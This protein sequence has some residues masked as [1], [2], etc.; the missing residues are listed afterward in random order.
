MKVF[1]LAFDLAKD[2][3]ERMLQR[4]IQT[5]PL[6]RAQ[7]FEIPEDPLPGLLTALTVCPQILYDLFAGEDC[8][9]DFIKHGEPDY[10]TARATGP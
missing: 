6:R 4:A 1:V 2:G 7:F 5:V 3:I 8:L 10:T 9:S